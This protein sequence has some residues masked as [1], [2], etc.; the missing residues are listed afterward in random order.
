MCS[1]DLLFDL[2]AEV[3]RGKSPA[4]AAQLKALGGLLGLLQRDPQEFLQSGPTIFSDG[5][6]SEL[7]LE[8][9]PKEKIEAL[10]AERAA[11]K[12]AKNYAEADRI[13]NELTVAGIVLED[14]VQGTSWR[15][16]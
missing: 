12:K 6:T 14:T 16:A 5:A 3:N 7:D 2:A 13:R 1:S 4:L 15:R 8:T 9:F 10:I 11:A